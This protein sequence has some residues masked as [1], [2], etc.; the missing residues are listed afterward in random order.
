MLTLQRLAVFA[1][2]AV[3]A[4]AQERAGEPS[5][6]TVES[7]GSKT[8]SGGSSGPATVTIAVGANGHVFT[9]NTATA[10]VGDI[11]RFNFYPSNHR[12]ARAEFKWP[13]IPYELANINKP[14][15]DSG[16]FTPQVVS[17]DPPHYEVRVNDTEPLFF[18]CAAPHSCVDYHM[19]GVINP[20]KTQSLA[21]QQDYADKV[22]YQLAPGDQFPSE[23][24]IPKPN[25]G[26][27]DG[28]T[29]PGN[30]NGGGGGGGGG[31]GLSGGAIAG[32]VIGAA[33]VII[34]GAALV[35][36]CG[37]RGGFDKAY[38]KSGLPTTTTSAAAAGGGGGG[39]GGAGGVA[40]VGPG[41]GAPGSPDMVEG[42]YANGGNNPKS[43][44]QASA[45][46][47]GGDGTYRN[48]MHGYYPGTSPSPGLPPYG[49][50]GAGA[51]AG[52]AA[53]VPGAGGQH[54][55]GYGHGGHGGEGVYG[56]PH[57]SPRADQYTPFIQPPPVELPTGD[58]PVSTQSP[59]PGYQGSEL[60]GTPGQEGQ[61]RHGAK[62]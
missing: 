43:P 8:T 31:G 40:G 3:T 51:A 27:G 20:N 18:Y 9:P 28:P 42:Y 37:R 47:F 11:I 19:I 32:I 35:Y 5:P 25:P 2:L 54:G 38:R 36:L 57:S 1:A 34:L 17:N 16:T 33:A 62:P 22:T 26:S 48:S 58:A 14:G 39:G 7:S 53:A 21:A 46:A 49:F 50:A 60:W 10:K 24:P 4:V 12:V 45:A 6:T 44:G 52:A 30:G 23:T 15:F 59:P 41:A 56:S 61:Y 13:C 55:Y 29:D